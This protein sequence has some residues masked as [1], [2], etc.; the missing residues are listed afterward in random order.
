MVVGFNE[1]QFALMVSKIFFD[2]FCC[3]V[4]HHVQFKCKA[5]RHLFL[6]LS[7]IRIENADV[8]KA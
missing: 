1:L 8:I 4:I 3:L 5:F 2:M 7:F 6:K